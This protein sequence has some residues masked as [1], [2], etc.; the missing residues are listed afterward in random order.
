VRKNF[1]PLKGE[2]DVCMRK[3]AIVIARMDAYEMEEEELLRLQARMENGAVVPAA[4]VERVG[5]ASNKGVQQAG[6][7]REGQSDKL[8]GM[9][10]MNE[11]GLLPILGDVIERDVM[12]ESGGEKGLHSSIGSINNDDDKMNSEDGIMK[13]MRY[14]PVAEHRKKSRF[15]LGR[16]RESNLADMGLQPEIPVGDADSI[17][18]GMTPDEVT[19]ARDEILARFKG[20][21]IEFLRNR[22]AKKK[23]VEINSQTQSNR[24]DIVKGKI[25]GEEL[26]SSLREPLLN[27]MLFSDSLLSRLRFSRDGSLDN[28]LAPKKQTWESVIK[29]DPIRHEVQSVGMSGQYYHSF[30][31]LYVL[32]RSTEFRQRV[33]GMSFLGDLLSACRKHLVRNDVLDVSPELADVIQ[34]EGL[35]KLLPLQW[36]DIW[37][38]VTYSLQIAKL[39]RFSMDDSNSVV[40]V[41][42]LKSLTQ[43][44]G[45][46]PDEIKMMEACDAHPAI[47]LP[48]FAFSHIQRQGYGTEWLSAPLDLQS[49]VKTM[50]AGQ[51][52][53]PLAE[54]EL[55][56]QDLARVDPLSGLLNM[57]LIDRIIHLMQRKDFQSD[58]SRMLALQCLHALAQSGMRACEKMASESLALATLSKSL[59]VIKNGNQLDIVILNILKLLFQSSKSLCVSSASQPIRGKIK[60]IILSNALDSPQ[61]GTGLDC[62]KICLQIWRAWL[63]NDAS[64]LY[65]DDAFS[66][67]CSVMFPSWDRDTDWK[68]AW[69]CAREGLL[70]A[71]VSCTKK[72]ISEECCQALMK[73]VLD[74]LREI[75]YPLSF[76]LD[77]NANSEEEILKYELN[78]VLSAAFFFFSC[79]WKLAKSW[80]ASH[81]LHLKGL[82]SE[83]SFFSESSVTQFWQHL[84]RNFGS[85]DQD[86]PNQE[87]QILSCGSLAYCM[88]EFQ[89][90][91][92][93]KNPNDMAC[94]FDEVIAM[95]GHFISDSAA[96]G[97]QIEQ[98]MQPWQIYSLQNILNLGRIFTSI[99]SF[100]L[101]HKMLSNMTA[102]ADTSM[103]LLVT[104][105]PGAD[106]VALR[107]LSLLFS[108]ENCHGPL[109]DALEIVKD[110]LKRFDILS[111]VESLPETLQAE[112]LRR[113]A[114]SGISKNILGYNLESYTSE[115]ILSIMQYD[116]MFSV[117]LQP[118]GEFSPS[119]FVVFVE[120]HC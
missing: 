16:C 85:Q 81:R 5:S 98:I 120:M 52:N 40:V 34:R 68:R 27:S 11:F 73:Q 8:D 26:N 4:K 56:E 63:I 36:I 112:S 24:T 84:C 79:S 95:L 7:L 83:F 90:I 41:E 96:R 76:V 39:I 42:S 111:G 101:D 94:T 37:H 48:R 86:L 35:G 103:R 44:I 2:E 14:F 92:G 59:T 117:I 54:E 57:N 10:K 78:A 58:T 23:N 29:R 50:V 33:M 97:V 20:S 99:T 12:R 21:T 100:A 110:Y 80:E 119:S 13:K 28:S 104:L 65:F 93:E 9:R 116:S 43:Y 74:W 25:P 114:L 106:D 31:E 46:S 49:T 108:R 88:T 70:L 72:N 64:I 69:P 6:N 17:I 91:W 113:D 32:C 18:S 61:N 62:F 51:H 55:D 15:T 66:S 38:H 89:L 60:A 67:L 19:E 75:P 102:V 45:A 47:G 105:P 1:V 71:A 77:E 22:G 115:K 30:D 118:E 107:L 109:N 53:A 82:F 3:T 87:I